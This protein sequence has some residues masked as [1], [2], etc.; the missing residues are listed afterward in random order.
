MTG[1]SEKSRNLDMEVS[2]IDKVAADVYQVMQEVN[3][4]A[5]EMAVSSTIIKKRE[6][7]GKCTALKYLELEYNG[8]FDFS[9]LNRLPELYTF[10][11][12]GEDAGS[13]EAGQ[14]GSK[15]TDEDYSQI[16]CLVVDGKW[17]RNPG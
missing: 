17:I 12:C 10:I 1:I 3:N 9:C 4:S 8:E 13:S 16:K 2:S 11:L 6:A 14:R 7:I 5:Q 15:I